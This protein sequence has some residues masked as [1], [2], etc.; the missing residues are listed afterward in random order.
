[1]LH[2]AAQIIPSATARSAL[3]CAVHKEQIS[4]GHV[5]KQ[6]PADKIALATLKKEQTPNLVVTVEEMLGLFR[7]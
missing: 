4:F 3:S 7:H 5:G 6:S 2:C 1:M